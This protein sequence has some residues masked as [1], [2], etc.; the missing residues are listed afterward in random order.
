MQKLSAISQDTSMTLQEQVDAI[1]EL[2][3]AYGI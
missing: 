3:S 1:N 2:T